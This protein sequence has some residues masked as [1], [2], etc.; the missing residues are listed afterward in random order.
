MSSVLETN[1]NRLIEVSVTGAISSPVIHYPY[2]ISA[3]GEPMVLPSVG[4]IRYNLR[5]G[6]YATGWM[7]DH[8]EPGVSIKNANSDAN[9]ALNTLSCIG[10]EAI[11]VSGDAKGSKGTVVGKHGGIEHVIVDFP[12]EVLEKLNI[13]DNV[14]VK[15]YGVG[16]KILNAL[17]VKVMNLDPRVLNLLN[18]KFE[19]GYLVVPVTHLVPASIMGSGLGDIQVYSG[20][21]DIQLFDRDTVDQYHLDDLRLGDLVAIINA[22]HTYGRIYRSG[23]I[24]IGVVVH[25]DCILAGHGP[26][27]TTIM[28]SSEGKIKPVIDPSANIAKILK[29]RDDF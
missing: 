29:L 23:A 28:T 16:L 3:F 18:L 9:I 7:A 20:D 19:Y 5:V 2:Q 15:A 8:V 4:G 10:N 25:T 13:G 12:V 27:V 17:N 24:S 11:V 21:Y 1:E 6:D 22:D 26:G 14:L